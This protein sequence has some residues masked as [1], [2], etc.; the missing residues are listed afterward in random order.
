MQTIHFK[1][2]ANN[3]FRRF[4]LSKPSLESLKTQVA[5]LFGI[6]SLEGWTIKYKD[7]ESQLVSIASDEELSY[8]VQC[9][10]GRVLH[11]NVTFPGGLGEC[12]WNKHHRKGRPENKERLAARLYKKQARIR[13]RLAS[14]ESS[15]NPRAKAQSSKLEDEIAAIAMELESLNIRDE[16]GN[17]SSNTSVELATAQPVANSPKHT[18]RKTVRCNKISCLQRKQDRIGEKLLELS[19]DPENPRKQA[20]ISKLTEKLTAISAKLEVME[21]EPSP[22]SNSSSSSSSANSELKGDNT[23]HQS[24]PVSEISADKQ[25]VEEVKSKFFSLRR[26]LHLERMNIISLGKVLGALRVI[27]RHGSVAGIAPVNHEQLAQTEISLG[28]AKDEFAAKK[29]VI[30]SKKSFCVT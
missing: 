6:D 9:I 12:T 20:K 13:E 28:L 1:V 7:E 11:L 16:K 14:L 18:E 30:Q 21:K 3:S 2:A 29:L 25:L 24:E 5:S 22:S 27:S 23:K 15:D 17:P 26:E 8:A 10:G 4:S 19:A